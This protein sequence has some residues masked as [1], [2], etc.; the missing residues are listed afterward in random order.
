VPGSVHCSPVLI[1]LCMA[2]DGASL[3]F[4]WISSVNFGVLRMAVA[5]AATAAA[6]VAR[7]GMHLTLFESY[8]G[9]LLPRG[10]QFSS[11]VCTSKHSGHSKANL[12]QLTCFN[13]S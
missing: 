5:S 12:L 1:P 4:G 11:L 13:I 3:R 10:A 9:S 6:R 7:Y 8:E 2:R